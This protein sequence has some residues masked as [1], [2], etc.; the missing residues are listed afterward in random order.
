MV[1]TTPSSGLG[2]SIAAFS[3]SSST[4]G[5]SLR[6]RS[7][8]FTRTLTKSPWVT[9]SPSSGSLTSVGIRSSLCKSGVGLFGVDFKFLNRLLDAR[10]LELSVVGQLL[11]RRKRDEARIHLEK[12]A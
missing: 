11:Q 2:T 5:W 6:M 10:A 8:T 4:T 7:P 9:F 1:L 12:V 3:V